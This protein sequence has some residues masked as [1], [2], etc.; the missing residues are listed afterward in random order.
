GAARH[1]D[2]RQRG[3]LDIA[4]C[5]REGAPDHRRA[6]GRAHR[7]A[8]SGGD[9]RLTGLPRRS[10]EN[11]RVP[12]RGREDLL[13]RGRPG[14]HHR[15]RRSGGADHRGVGG[16]AAD[17]R[18]ARP[19]AYAVSRRDRA[20]AAD[21]RRDQAGR[22]QALRDRAGG[23]DGRAAAAPHPH[24]DPRPPRLGTARRAPAD[25]LQQGDL[26]PGDRA[27]SWRGA[28]LRG[29]PR[30]AIA[31][32]H[33]PLLPRPGTNPGR[34]GGGV[35]GDALAGAGAPPRRRT[36]RLAGHRAGRGGCSGLAAGE[37]VARRVRRGGRPLPRLLDRRRLARP[38]SVRF[39]AGRVAPREGGGAM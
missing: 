33:R 26:Y 20:G 30:S 27:R 36:P 23:R 34:V 37:G 38:R 24:R 1:P 7:H 10:D 11:H 8:R 39:G 18:S 2:H 22:A 6:Q 13:C 32:A 14:H 35:H 9:R 16:A 29:A 3:G 25:R 19:C 28:R 15:H 17:R 5:G 12:A 21:V 4:R 31:A